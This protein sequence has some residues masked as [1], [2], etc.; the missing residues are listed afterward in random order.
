MK[1]KI[2]SR[3][4]NLDED[5]ELIMQ[6]LRSVYQ[7][8]KSL[9]NWFPDRFENS[10]DDH[11]SDIRIWEE[12]DET[13]SPPQHKLVAFA[14]PEDP[15]CYFIQIHPD[16]SFL[17]REIIQWI[18][19]HSVAK[20]TDF[21]QEQKL[22]I[23][24]VDGNSSREKILTELG[25]KKRTDRIYGHLRFRPLDMPIEEY[26]LPD[27]FIIRSVEGKPDHE[28]LARAV[29]TVF[30]HGEWFNAEL[31]E[32]IRQ[33]SFH[34]PDLDLVAV[35]PNGTIASF[36]TFRVD[37]ESRITQL[38]PMGTLPEFRKLGLAK[39]LLSEGFKRLE[40]YNPTLIY[41]G[42]AATNP[43]AL[44]LY[45]S[46]FPEKIDMHIWTKEI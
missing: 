31:S 1:M 18:E 15:F 37:P 43:A 33:R 22:N 46:S 21:K 7:E 39:A 4:Y 41:I 42:G 17:E 32:R 2:I 6:F 24:T 25:F 12:I 3:N 26:S 19:S 35:A 16:Y 44:R 23:I 40:K 36:C 29:R 11:I 14:N 38:E 10:C 45:D 27:G 9:Q 13:R 28:Q 34:K 5:L 30:G 20:K 8:T